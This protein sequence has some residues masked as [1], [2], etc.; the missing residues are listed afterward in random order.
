MK[1]NF[2][3]PEE[4]DRKLGMVFNASIAFPLLLFVWLYLEI[5]ENEFSGIWSDSNK[6]QILGYSL[7]FVSGLVILKGFQYFKA[8]KAVNDVESLKLKLA[9]YYSGA[10]KLYIVVAI[11]SFILVV[12]LY[13]TTAGVIIVS[14]VILLFVMS[15]FRPRPKRYVDDLKLVGEDKEIVLNEKYRNI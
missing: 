14:Y 4:F 15:Y 7:S 2:N 6:G 3:T 9:S 8:S 5:K 12:G 11:S 10:L 1:V 13:L